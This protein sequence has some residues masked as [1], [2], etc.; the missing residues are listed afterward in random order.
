M[1]EK[2]GK[3][4]TAVP[5]SLIAEALQVVESGRKKKKEAP[6]ASPASEE[7]AAEVAVQ[8][9]PPSPAVAIE[10]APSE[11][12]KEYYERLLRMAAELDNFRKRTAREKEEWQRLA[13]EKILLELLP[14]AD[15][16]QRALAIAAPADLTT[17]MGE[18][19]KLIQ[20]ALEAVLKK[21]GVEK[22]N[23]HH[24]P[25]DP[26]YHE[27]I[28]TRSEPDLEPDLVLEVLQDGYLLQGRLLRP[29]K[30]V[31]NQPPAVPSPETPHS[32][33]DCGTDKSCD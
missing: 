5:E 7:P 28:T 10:A 27:A 12:E 6:A 23:A 3:V 19:L 22:I 4:E 16:F 9:P 30:V 32:E 2:K 1:D 31:V 21:Q 17:P 29:C 25:F 20:H 33:P 14:L 15:N 8:V 18:G 11:K 13:T 26:L 24:R